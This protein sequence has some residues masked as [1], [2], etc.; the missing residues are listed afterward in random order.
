MTALRR[1]PQSLEMVMNGLGH[2]RVRIQVSVYVSVC[3]CVTCPYVTVSVYHFAPHDCLEERTSQF[4][5]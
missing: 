3:H 5:V 1:G 4:R 2:T